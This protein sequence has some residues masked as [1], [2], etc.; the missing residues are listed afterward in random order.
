MNTTD[1][2]D[3]QNT[4]KVHISHATSI[5]IQ[6]KEFKGKSYTDIRKFTI[7]PDNSLLPTK[8]GIMILDILIPDI[9]KHLQSSI[10][11]D[12]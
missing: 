5:I 1:L 10:S 9:I 7:S 8:K 2:K 12:K 3:S 4:W 11:D 6:K